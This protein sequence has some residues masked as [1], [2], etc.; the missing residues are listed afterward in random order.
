[1]NTDKSK[2]PADMAFSKPGCHF[3]TNPFPF[4]GFLLLRSLFP[5]C[6]NLRFEFSWRRLPWLLV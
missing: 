5:I 2:R 6:V 4:L 3:P 1:M